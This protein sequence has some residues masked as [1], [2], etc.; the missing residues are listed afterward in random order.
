MCHRECSLHA[1]S[2]S[3]NDMVYS[4]MLT[5][6][7]SFNSMMYT[8]SGKQTTERLWEETL[9]ELDFAGVRSITKSLRD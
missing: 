6:I 9:D 3:A 2:L 7:F 8:P 5:L 4:M 1:I